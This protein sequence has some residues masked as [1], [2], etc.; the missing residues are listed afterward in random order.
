MLQKLNTILCRFVKKLV[1]SM[2]ATTIVNKI[3]S[4]Y[5]DIG[6]AI[7]ANP[8]ATPIDE[9]SAI[10]NRKLVTKHIIRERNSHLS[11]QRKREDGY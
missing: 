10:E 7:A 4:F 9:Y 5:L 6:H 8:A 3:V 1:P 11:R 2:A